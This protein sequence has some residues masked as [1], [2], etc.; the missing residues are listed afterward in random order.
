MNIILMGPPGA[1][2]GTQAAKLVEKYG[3]KQISTG[4]LF[5]KAIK[6]ETKFGVIA[7]YFI[8]FGYLV[9]DDFTIQM[10]QEY[11]EE[12][13]NTEEFKNGFIL[14]GFPRTIIQARKLA[15][16]CS[17]FNFK[18]DAVI[19][20]DIP[21]DV[22]VKRLS[23]RRTCADCG[24]SYHIVYNPPKKEG[25]CDACGGELTQR[26]DESEEAVQ[27]RIDTYN[28]QTKP[29]IDYYRNSGLYEEINGL[30][31]VDAVFADIIKALEK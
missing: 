10:I 14:D 24:K 19:N 20:L 11:L 28:K 29:L 9:P 8:S 30:Q 3:L 25:V 13:I 26:S 2:K 1:G 12:N 27:V 22:L 6:E 15:D 5:R 18:I 7:K 23:G 31:D 17:M 4:D 21:E 16:I